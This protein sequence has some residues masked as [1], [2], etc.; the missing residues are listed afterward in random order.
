[1]IINYEEQSD[2]TLFLLIHQYNNILQDITPAVKEFDKVLQLMEEKLPTIKPHL[3][4]LTESLTGEAKESVKY[5]ND[6]MN[7]TQTLT[8]DSITNITNVLKKEFEK[9]NRLTEIIT[10]RDYH[11]KK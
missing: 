3:N 9:L 6:L 10:A 11:Q 1:M 2:V 7:D 4:T 5:I 8:V